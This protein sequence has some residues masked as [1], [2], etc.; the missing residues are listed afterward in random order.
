MISFTD[1][2]VIAISSRALFNLDESHRIYEEEGIAAYQTHQIENENTPLMPGVAFPLVK[3]LLALKDP[4]SQEPLVEII[5][6]SRNSADTGLRVFNSIQHHQ[7][8]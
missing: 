5:L 8:T 6:L 3:K 4:T 1:K 7:L 2:L